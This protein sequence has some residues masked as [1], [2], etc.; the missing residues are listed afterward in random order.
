MTVLLQQ[1]R[2]GLCLPDARGEDALRATYAQRACVTLPRFL[3]APLLAHL[4]A[5]VARAAWRDL[6][7]DVGELATELALLDDRVPGILA[8][9]VQDPALVAFVQRITGCDAIGSFIGR[10][11]RMDAG[12][13]HHDVWHGDDDDNRMVALSVNLSPRVYDGGVLE[14]RERGSLRLL[15]RVANTGP[16]DAILF[17]I[18]HALEHRVTDVAGAASKIAYAGWFQREPVVRLG[19]AT[20]PAGMPRPRGGP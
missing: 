16:G 11:Y 18:D 4:Q 10:V 14:L 7:H 2:A 5:R 13:G 12:A 19:G 1:T 8:L 9:L 17:R 15:Q 20:P 6:V 3:D